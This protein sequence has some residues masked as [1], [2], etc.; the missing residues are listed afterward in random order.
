M[1]ACVHVSLALNLC[2]ACVCLHLQKSTINSQLYAFCLSYPI[3]A[4]AWWLASFGLISCFYS[5]SWNFFFMKIQIKTDIAINYDFQRI[6]SFFL[7]ILHSSYGNLGLVI[8]KHQFFKSFEPFF[9]C[10]CS[11][12]VWFTNLN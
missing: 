4:F 12:L 10:S 7:I 8:Q 11:F 6:Y 5:I 1:N 2:C 9:E 3:R